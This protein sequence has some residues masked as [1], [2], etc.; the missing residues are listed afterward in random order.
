MAGLDRGRGSCCLSQGS[1]SGIDFRI[2]IQIAGSRGNSGRADDRAGA[3]GSVALGVEVAESGQAH[4][5]AVDGLRIGEIVRFCQKR[6]H[7]SRQVDVFDVGVVGAG[8]VRV[9][10]VRVRADEVN[11][12][13][14]AAHRGMRAV[15]R[16]AAVGVVEQR[17]DSDVAKNAGAAVS[18]GVGALRGV[19]I[20]RDFVDRDAHAA[21]AQAVAAHG[22][23]GVARGNHFRD[24]IAVDHQVA[25]AAK[26]GIA[27]HGGLGLSR[28]DGAADQAGVQAAHRARFGVGLHRIGVANR[29]GTD[30]A[31]AFPGLKGGGE[32]ARGIRRYFH[33]GNVDKVGAGG[34]VDVRQRKGR[35]VVKHLHRAGNVERCAV[36]IGDGR[37]GNLGIGPVCVCAHQRYGSAAVAAHRRLGRGVARAAVGIEIGNHAQA[38]AL[39]V[40]ALDNGLVRAGNVAADLVDGDTHAAH[41]NVDALDVG[42]GARRSHSGDGDIAGGN[43]VASGGKNGPA[44]HNAGSRADARAGVCVVPGVGDVRVHACNTER[45]AVAGL[46]R[47]GLRV[48]IISVVNVD[49]ARAHIARSDCLEIAF[50]EGLQDVHADASQIQRAIFA[51]YGG[52]RVGIALGVKVE[53]AAEHQ[54]CP[55]DERMVGGVGAGNGGVCHSRNHVDAH[56][57]AVRAKVRLG[58]GG[59]VLVQFRVDVRALRGQAHILHHGLLRGADFSGHNVGGNALHTALQ[60]WLAHNCLGQRLADGMHV[61]RTRVERA[62]TADPGIGGAARVGHGHVDGQGC[63]VHT[64]AGCRRSEFNIGIGGIVRAHTDAAGAVFRFA[65]GIFG[66]FHTRVEAALRVAEGNHGSGT[67]VTEALVG[68]LGFGVRVAVGLHVHRARGNQR[69]RSEQGNRGRTAVGDGHIGFRFK[70]RAAAGKQFSGRGDA[71]V[72]IEIGNNGDAARLHVRAIHFSALLASEHGDCDRSRHRNAAD[73]Q[74]GQ[75]SVSARAAIGKDGKRIPGDQLPI[76]KDGSN[77][78]HI[79]VGN[80]AVDADGHRAC[81]AG[82][83]LR[84]CFGAVG[85]VFAACI[86]FDDVGGNRDARGVN[87]GTVVRTQ[88]HVADRNAHRGTANRGSRQE[89]IG[90]RGVVSVNGNSGCLNICAA[91]A[92]H[93][94]GLVEHQQHIAVD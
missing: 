82:N 45:D 1:R 77:V 9:G 16:L 71:V 19:E 28:V 61:H 57:R 59:L 87:N 92:S 25:V 31:V 50:S 10:V 84:S 47:N 83:R 26:A 56:R 40:A 90:L 24:Y 55:V 69:R 46:C 49:V 81:V 80:S 38:C 4:G 74:A 34:F 67:D 44:I 65:V 41:A 51:L 70:Q 37:G 60:R 52:Q 30:G 6:D 7:R 33:D 89:G 94:A 5:A 23:D 88:M 22:G 29:D 93:A 20:C 27:A 86:N 72:L 18:E 75:R 36:H 35:G 76:A 8:S 79:V 3:V 85:R 53:I 66:N 78:A 54:R 58:H 17:A 12:A 39:H 64:D 42:K 15:R 13:S 73:V 91:D 62:Q 2:H 14:R 21:D 32:D 63:E 43:E 48:G 11:A 68:D